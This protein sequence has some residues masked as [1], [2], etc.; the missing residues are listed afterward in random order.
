MDLAVAGG[1]QDEGQQWV[2]LAAGG[3]T[4]YVEGMVGGFVTDA[5]LTFE[6][7]DGLLVHGSQRR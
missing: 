3:Q 2:V 1:T 5:A 6:V 7:F 4:V